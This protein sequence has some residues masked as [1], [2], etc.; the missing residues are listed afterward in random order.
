MKK[1]TICSLFMAGLLGF[2][3]TARADKGLTVGE[4]H[5]P[6]GEIEKVEFV[7]DGVIVHTIDGVK[8]KMTHSEFGEAGIHYTPADENENPGVGENDPISNVKTTI[9]R[10]EGEE[11]KMVCVFETNDT[12]PVNAARYKLKKQQKALWD[13]VV[14]FSGNLDYN[15]ASRPSTFNK[16]D[17]QQRPYFYANEGIQYMLDNKDEI[18]KPLK[19][20]GIKVIMGIL[21][22]HDG[23]G[24]LN[25][26]EDGIESFVEDL[27][28][29]YDDYYIDGFFWDEE[30]AEYNFQSR[31]GLTA[32]QSL[33]N[34][35]KLLTKV[36]EVIP[37][38]ENIVYDYGI[39][40]LSSFIGNV[41]DIIDG[42]MPNYGST[43]SNWGSKYPGTTNKKWG[44]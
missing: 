13:Y 41:D 10:S 25:L 22:N 6:A 34:F 5:F 18:L 15:N 11:I 35:I 38:A 24:L 32:S 8:T 42:I 44:G 4:K 30:Y 16:D 21:P 39:G 19:D 23:A 29:L 1:K 36:K 20:M 31:P 33:G 28:I 40:N 14:L 43:A 7:E 9:N 12:N 37:E 27:K 2:S 26:S 17:T 3:F